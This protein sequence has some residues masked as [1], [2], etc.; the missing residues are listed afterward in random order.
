MF[1]LG[2]SELLVIGVT[3][4]IVVGPKDLPAMFRTLGQFT[5][6]MRRM[7]REFSRAMEEAADASGAKDIA[8]DLNSLRTMTN[9]RAA[10]ASAFKKATGLD[11]VDPFGEDAE[12]FEAAAGTAKAPKDDTAAAAPAAGGTGPQT[13]ALRAERA[14]QAEKIR[15]YAAAKAQARRD[16][17]AA[18]S[19]SAAAPPA[20]D[21]PETGDTAPAPRDP[22]AATGSDKV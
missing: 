12:D 13:E 19:G 15:D 7:A 11:P 3:A 10:G 5:A 22:A 6:K 8:K 4:L 14:E 16:A 17:E 1:D 9:P 18:G 21:R 2:W 20:S